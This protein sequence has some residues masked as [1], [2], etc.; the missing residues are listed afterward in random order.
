MM[1]GLYFIEHNLA[2]AQAEALCQAIGEALLPI[3]LQPY[4]SQA[5]ADQPASLMEVCQRTYLST[6]GVFDLSVASPDLYLKIGISIGLNRPTLIIAG[7]SMASTIPPVLERANTWLYTPPLKPER[8][9]QRAASRALDRASQPHTSTTQALPSKDYC[10]FCGQL[11]P[12][13]RK[14]T[15]SRGFLLLD[16]TQACWQTLREAIRTGLELTDLTPIYL[17]Q[18]RARTMPL[19]CE[20]RLGVIAAEFAMLDASETCTPEQYIALGLAIGA[21]RPWLLVSSQP[22]SLPPIL[23]QASYLQY[24][25]EQDLQQRLGPFLVSSVYSSRSATKKGV[26]TR[27]ELPFWLRLQDWISQFKSGVSRAME[28]ALQLLLIEEGQLKQRCRLTQSATITAGRD[29]ECDLVIESQSVTRLHAE[30][31]FSGQELLV[32]DRESTNGTFVSGNRIP[33]GEQV[34]L[35]IGD[36]IRIGPAEVIVWDDKEL[37]DEIKQYLP[38]S[39]QAIPPAATIVISLADGLVLADGKVPVARLSASEADVVETMHNKG[40]NTTATS[41]I[42]EIVYGTDKISRMIVASF[43]DGLRAKIE[44]SPSTPRFLTSV[45]GKG[46]RLHTRGG[47]LVIRSR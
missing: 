39:E 20:T 16:A 3:G 14:R 37:S 42:A 18:F 40:G 8:D 21:C 30:F 15:Q 5:D 13:W 17:T 27:L 32:V 47:Q 10:I 23:R 35:K 2:R 12:G 4:E 34:S 45:P 19:L 46:Y 43:I 7:Q 11:C 6:L 44:S 24:S 9:L 38:E 22:A 36:R 28:G 26:T 33:V 25:D 31:I 1:R 29:P 41:E